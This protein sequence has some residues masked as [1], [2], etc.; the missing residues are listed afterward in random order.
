LRVQ[1]A[2]IF[3]RNTFRLIAGLQ[4][5]KQPHGKPGPEL[6]PV[7]DGHLR[8]KPDKIFPIE[9]VQL[10]TLQRGDLRGDPFV[11]IPYVKVTARWLFG[12]AH[13]GRHPLISGRLARNTDG[14]S[15]WGGTVWPVGWSDRRHRTARSPAS[16]DSSATS[17]D[18]SGTEV[19][20][21]MA[22]LLAARA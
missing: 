10:A 1:R 4:Q 18:G 13:A 5:I 3:I 16:P 22:D 8:Q 11:L 7:A 21:L 17:D 9:T 19:S 20:A 14:E 6:A 2:S 12:L 15:R